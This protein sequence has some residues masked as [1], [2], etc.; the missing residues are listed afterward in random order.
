MFF[1]SV[2]NYL[3]PSPVRPG[4]FSIARPKDL[5]DGGPIFDGL[6]ETI[7]YVRA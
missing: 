3:L 1:F 4:A 7:G 6:D 2:H 5:S